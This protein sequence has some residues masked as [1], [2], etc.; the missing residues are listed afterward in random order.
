M[1]I[2]TLSR[3]FNTKSMQIKEQRRVK[4]LHLT[5]GTDSADNSNRRSETSEKHGCLD[6]RRESK[7][8]ESGM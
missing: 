7:R 6:Q 5:R 8:S 3:M 2:L 4:L 1:I